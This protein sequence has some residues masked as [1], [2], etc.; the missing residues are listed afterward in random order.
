MNYSFYLK[1]QNDESL[2]PTLDKYTTITVSA[3]ILG[4]FIGS[5]FAGFIADKKGRRFTL[6]MAS[7]IALIGNTM[8]MA[9]SDASYI[10]MSIGRLIWGISL[11]I[12]S[13]IGPLYMSEVLVV[14]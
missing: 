5:F 2:K 11:G 9:A 12:I 13:S 10:F 4:A 8:S 14:K 6:L 3:P 1:Y 7:A